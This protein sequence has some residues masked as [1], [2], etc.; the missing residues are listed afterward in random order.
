MRL[1]I[2]GFGSGAKDAGALDA[3][4]TGFLDPQ[5]A[6]KATA[7]APKTGARKGS[8][9][10]LATGKS[11]TLSRKSQ[12]PPP[13]TE[14]LKKRVKW[15]LAHLEEFRQRLQPAMDTGN[16]DE[17]VLVM[18]NYLAFIAAYSDT[19]AYDAFELGPA[20][21]EYLKFFHRA[22][23]EFAWRMEEKAFAEIAE[24]ELQPWQRMKEV[25]SECISGS[26]SCMEELPTLVDF[27]Q[28][29]SIVVLGCGKVPASLF[30]LQDQTNIPAIVGI[31][32]LQEAVDC[33]SALATKFKLD[34][35]RV[36]NADAAKLD[37]SFF[38]AIYFGPFATPRADVLKQIRSTARPNATIILREPQ[39]TGSLAFERVLP[40]MQPAFNLIKAGDAKKY[41]G[42]FMLRHYVLKPR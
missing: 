19:V 4:A 5:P 39:F 26:Y 40:F 23:L 20:Y 12:T 15:L 31:D 7:K 27:S 24:A 18:Q 33:A 34:R 6:Q 9:P 28:M 29:R 17:F 35:V 11:R 3:D 37:Y 14:S 10:P 8:K 32:N 38:D 2:F 21:P 22:S 36:I 1:N 25:V 30:F 16:T 42:R 41:L 13:N